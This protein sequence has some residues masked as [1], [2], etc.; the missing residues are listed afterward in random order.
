MIAIIC[1]TSASISA[2][3]GS[4]SS[5]ASKP[6]RSP[7]RRASGDDSSATAVR[8]SADPQS[9]ARAGRGLLHQARMAPMPSASSRRRPA[10]PA[11]VTK[12]SEAWKLA[13][14]AEVGLQCEMGPQLRRA[15]R[16]QRVLEPLIE[17]PRRIVQRRLHLSELARKAAAQ[18][19]ELLQ[20][21][22][23]RA[24]LQ[25]CERARRRPG[26]KP[27]SR[28]ASPACTS[29]ASGGRSGEGVRVSGSTTS[30]SAPPARRRAGSTA[31]RAA[32]RPIPSKAPRS[33]VT[34]ACASGTGIWPIRRS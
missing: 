12:S 28:I 2:A 20:N 25:R 21:F 9:A 24:R 7:P 23:S 8:S 16:H 1:S 5:A 4:G 34:L 11:N 27:R 10:G 30:V 29:V 19:V 17:V 31:A 22:A 13:W 33:P 18:G 32:V 26:M 3:M 15:E 14:L 6:C